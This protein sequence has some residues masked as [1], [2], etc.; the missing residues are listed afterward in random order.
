MFA[1]MAQVL[2]F[3]IHACVVYARL[4]KMIDEIKTSMHKIARYSLNFYEWYQCLV[5]N[6]DLMR[7][8]VLC[9]F[10]S[11]IQQTMVLRMVLNGNSDW[12]HASKVHSLHLSIIWQTSLPHSFKI[13]V[14]VQAFKSKLLAYMQ[15]ELTLSIWVFE[16]CPYPLHMIK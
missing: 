15:G 7:Y 5:Y 1:C 11:G 14:Y 12:Y 8:L 2:I 4:Q 9:C 16:T 13:H 3:P 10:S 6:V